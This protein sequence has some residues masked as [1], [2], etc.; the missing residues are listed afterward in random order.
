VVQQGTLFLIDDIGQSFLDAVFVYRIPGGQIN[1]YKGM[2]SL[3]ISAMVK[4]VRCNT[5]L[6]P[7]SIRW[8]KVCR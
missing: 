4:I 7:N 5:V 3:K 8:S 6:E 1:D 2:M